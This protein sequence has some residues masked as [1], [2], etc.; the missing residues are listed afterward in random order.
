MRRYRKGIGAARG[1]QTPTTSRLSDL[2]SLPHPSSHNP[3]LNSFLAVLL[4]S[5]GP[6][7]ALITLHDCGVLPCAGIDPVEGEQFV[8]SWGN[9]RQAKLSEGIGCRHAMKIEA[10]T[11][12]Y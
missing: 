5:N 10:M 2:P 3:H 6:A 9:V 4:D 12:R 8:R 7:A 1:G 11:Q